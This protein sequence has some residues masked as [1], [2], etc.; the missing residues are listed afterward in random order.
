MTSPEFLNVYVS[1]EQTHSKS[2][3]VEF[4]NTENV[5]IR[6]VPTGRALETLDRIA[7]SL[8]SSEGCRS[9]AVTGPYGSG[10]SSFA[11]FLRHLVDSKG[12][13]SKKAFA[14]LSEVDEEFSKKLQG[15][16]NT[17][18]DRD[19]G[20]MVGMATAQREPVVQ[21]MRRA[22]ESALDKRGL[23]KS[24]S[25][26][27]K[28][29]ASSETPASVV[30]QT[31]RKIT[32]EMPLLLVIDEFGKNLESFKEAPG[33]SDLF[34]LQQIAEIA[35][36]SN[37]YPLV[38]LTLKHLAFN[39][40]SNDLDQGP[41]RELAK[42]QGRFE[43]IMFIENPSETRRLVSQLFKSTNV[44]FI[45]KT[46]NWLTNH[47][48]AIAA[49]GLDE[50]LESDVIQKSL[51]LH[52]MTLACLPEL[53]SRFAQNDR[54]L[55]A[56]LG[57]N[58]P[59]SVF[60]FIEQTSWN[61]KMELPLIRLDHLYDYFVE[62]VSTSI[63]T[64]DL[65]SRW[66]EIETRIRDT[67]GLS[68][69]EVRVLKTVGVLNLISAGGVYRASRDAISFSLDDCRY[70]DSKA[71]ITKDAIEKLVGSGI[72]VYREFADEYRIWFGT[73]YPLQER[74]Q[75][76][77]SAAKAK[78]LVA[79]LSET[80][81]LSPLV[82]SRHS[83][84]K[85]VMRIFE[86]SFGD[87]QSIRDL[88]SKEAPTTDGHLLLSV[89]SLVIPKPCEMDTKRPV[90]VA[91]PGDLTQVAET[92]IEA[93]ALMQV[94]SHANSTKADRIAR[95]EIAE[96]LALVTTKLMT[97][98]QKAWLSSEAHLF[99]VDAKIVKPMSE[100]SLSKVLSDICDEVYVSCPEIRNEMISR[101]EVT[102]QGAR[103]RRLLSE[104]MIYNLEDD[105]FGIEG[106]GPERSMYEAILR[107]SKIHVLDE[108][109]LKFGLRIPNDRK[110]SWNQVSKKIKELFDDSRNERL[111]LLTA[112]EVLQE[113][114][115]GLKM[116]LIPLLLFVEIVRREADILLYEHGSLVT[117]VDDAIAERL[118]KNPNHF[119]IKVLD[120]TAEAQ[121]LLSKYADVMFVGRDSSE[122]SIVAIGKKIYNE[123]RSLSRYS[124]N[125]RDGISADAKK[126]RSAIREAT[127]LDVLL[128]ESLPAAV[129]RSPLSLGAPSKSAIETM[130]KV[131]KAFNELIDS[132]DVMLG[133]VHE[134]ITSELDLK[135]AVG[136]ENI[137][138]WTEPRA[139][140][141]RDG[142]FEPNMKALSGALLRRGVSDREWLEHVALVVAGGKVPHGWDDDQFNLFSLSARNFLGLFVRLSKLADESKDEVGSVDEAVLVSVTTGSGTEIQER[143]YLSRDESNLRNTLV[144]DAVSALEETGLSSS[145]AFAALISELVKR[146]KKK[147]VQK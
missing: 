127:E 93:Y 124:L 132:Y 79:L 85:G 104:A 129:G 38:L 30:L 102:G 41:R 82:A 112:C 68:N 142:A 53:C 125:T 51:P 70:D 50:I 141:I 121:V 91:V 26:L 5:N 12:Q 99:W 147:M 118:I 146:W 64:S 1:L 128:L 4:S 61:Q 119:S 31:V 35:Q 65:S 3:N 87:L 6:Y 29:V 58:D 74:L 94:T 139:L 107:K 69:S 45:K 18:D 73:D 32:S 77:R 25:S 66:I 71:N 15:T 113:P 72:L 13:N 122:A 59:R 8:S 17:I 86:R 43:E 133:R 95:R 84:K 14:M 24:L 134:V 101:R 49:A 126:V 42:V 78:T 57:S 46:N 27:K 140:R 88:G 98:I 130:T 90:V 40:Y 109:T 89:E 55:F 34:I 33:E 96:R 138:K 120:Q 20:F 60:S 44:P 54:T 76:E 63:S 105:H 7:E 2:V 37:K 48:D 115:F 67:A 28:L 116:G 22:V 137:I 136:I 114:P 108:Q 11:V 145:D 97:Q 56:Y 123:V 36:S 52:P 47:A 23:P 39:E 83:Q 9:F 144:K 19:C 100:G 106:F 80:V 111:S 92:A 110:N 117:A 135:K 81:S 62:S 143:F 103:A 21:T 10:K 131:G 75:L 16:L